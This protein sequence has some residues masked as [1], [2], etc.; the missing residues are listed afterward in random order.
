M[1]KILKLFYIKVSFKLPSKSDVII[2]DNIS[3]EEFKFALKDIKYFILSV[4]LEEIKKIYISWKIIFLFIKHILAGVKKSYLIALIISLSPKIIITLED[5]DLGFSK[6]AKI[7]H[8][9]F[10]FIAVQNS[11]RHFGQYRRLFEKKILK[12]NPNNSLFLPNY[13]CFGKHE[14]IDTKKEKIKVKNYFPVGLLRL[15]NYLQFKKDKNIKSIKKKYDIALICEMLEEKKKLWKSE[16]LVEDYMKIF[17]YSIQAAINNNLKI[18]FILKSKKNREKEINFYKKY[19]NKNEINFFDGNKMEVDRENYKSYIMMEKSEVVIAFHSTMLLE[20]LALNGKILACNFSKED[21][22]NFP[23]DCF[24][25]LIR[26]NFSEFE[27]KL[28]NIINFKDQI[29]LQEIKR[30]LFY[31]NNDLTHKLINNRV[32]ELLD[33]E[34]EQ[35]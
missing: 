33:K 29:Y 16:K 21:V 26:P 13:F 18:I 12:E 35:N 20:K 22:F 25:R 9:K 2:F 10:I 17:K 8:K 30:K 27:N 23:I 1:K 14:I 4:R 19:L 7:L 3:S 5:I 31:N 11:A 6:I 32:Q 24:F 28:L 34:Y 15:S